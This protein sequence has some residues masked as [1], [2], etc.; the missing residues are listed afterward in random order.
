MPFTPRLA[1]SGL[2]AALV[3]LTGCGGTESATDGDGTSALNA[4]STLPP[5]E[6]N[7][8]VYDGTT[9]PAVIAGCTEPTCFGAADGSDPT[10]GTGVVT[11]AKNNIG[12]MVAGGMKGAVYLYVDG[13][14]ATS[15]RPPKLLVWSATPGTHTLQTMAYSSDGVAGWSPTLTIT[16]Q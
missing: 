12:W 13:K 4:T 9:Q 14:R 2:F 5:P 15:V 6:V 7:F 11:N 16:A 10:P 8:V 1:L 3:A